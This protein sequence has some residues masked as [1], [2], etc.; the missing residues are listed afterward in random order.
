MNSTTNKQQ[1][2]LCFG[3]L[4]LRISPDENGRWLDQQR[5]PLYLRGSEAN[6]SIV[7]TGWHIPVSYCSVLP[8][9]FLG[10]QCADWLS[11]KHIDISNVI[12]QGERLGLFYLVPGQEMKD[13]TVIYDRKYSS[14]SEIKPGTID[15]Q[16][17]FEGISWFH[18]SAISPA[19]NQAVADVCLEGVKAAH[20]L[21]ITISIDL[22]YRSRLWQ[23]GKH[24]VEI[25]PELVN[26][27]DLIMGN[28]WSIENMIGISFD[29]PL[30]SAYS[31]ADCIHYSGQT[32]ERI[33]DLFPKCMAV[34]H[35]FRFGINDSG[36]RYFA[37]LQPKA[38]NL[39]CSR[40]Y[41]ADA[42][43]DKVGTGDCFMAGLIYGFCRGL[44][45]RET[46]EFS[47]AAAFKKF[48]IPGDSTSSTAEEIY[49]FI[50]SNAS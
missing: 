27:C 43:T 30:E 25:I 40:E 47:A 35:T 12:Y 8:G 46:I 28:L 7:L 17:I 19:L 4:L 44:P 5:A 31:R 33:F 32:A 45:A 50:A 6:V 37:T 9:N 14:F 24:P 42:I 23:Y 29:K 34:A 48:F 16:K 21:G 15:W 38:Q 20:Q 18:L 49:E 2:V 13:D 11:E 26:Y 3:E 36:V 1:K 39:L 22:N 41:T 10:R